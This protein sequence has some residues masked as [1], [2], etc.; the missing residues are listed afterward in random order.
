[1]FTAILFLLVGPVVASAT[2]VDRIAAQVDDQLVLSSDVHLEQRLST[3]DPSPSPFWNGD[4]KTAMERLIDA[5]MIR[6]AAGDIDI[7]QPSDADV[8]ARRLEVRERVGDSDWDL[9]LVRM[10]QTEASLNTVLRRRLIVERYLGR[11]NQTDIADVA[12][13][14][15]TCDGMVQQLQARSRVRRIALQ[16]QP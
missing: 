11:N 16:G 6:L 12:A 14:L 13:W 15:A 3:L 10:G 1:M 9:F 2:V 8:T 4:H 5:A 7:Y